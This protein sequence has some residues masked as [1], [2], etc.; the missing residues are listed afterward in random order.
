MMTPGRLK[1][2]TR[3]FKHQKIAV[4]GD[5]FLDKYLEIDSELA[6]T[7]LET[8]KT[9]HQ[10]VGS[11]HSPGA[12]GTIV[13]NLSSLG[14]GHIEA[15]GFIGDDGAGLEL[16]RELAF[17]N[18]STEGL[19]EVPGKMTPV[20]M[21]PRDIKIR[22]L[23]GEHDRYDFKNRQET[24]REIGDKIVRNLDKALA[25]ADAVIIA[26]QVPEV[27]CGVLTGFV[28]SALS[29]RA[30]RCPAKV[31]WADSRSRIRHFKHMMTKPNQFECMEIE[32]PPPGTSLD[33]EE[34][35]E[36][37]KKLRVETNAPVFCTLGPKGILVSDPEVLLVPGLRLEGVLDT[38]GA[39]D[40]VSA[41]ASLALSAG[42]SCY[43]AALVGNLAA[44]ITVQQLNTTGTA[45]VEQLEE[46]LELWHRQRNEAGETL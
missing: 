1:E 7:S 19:F 43:E 24:S 3:Q 34:L 26:D 27:D 25:N 11:Y 15:I 42:A 21:K 41:G 37:V 12:A 18:C 29:D 23:K 9:A 20:Y 38:T 33:P 13:A 46:Q 31:F 28:R 4:I 32:N 8:Q 17:L 39:G 10:V 22:G 40:S 6:E 45:R 14:A 44:S 5:F 35:I 36:A 30:S 16:V 2:L